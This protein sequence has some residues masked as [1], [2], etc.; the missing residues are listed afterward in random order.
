MDKEDAKSL[1]NKLINAVY[2]AG[3]HSLNPDSLIVK[4]EEKKALKLSEEIRRH[5]TS[6]KCCP[7]CPQSRK[8]KCGIDEVLEKV[9]L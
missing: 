4:S 3:Q 6:K 2:A 5:L 9:E 8:G 1:V 7:L